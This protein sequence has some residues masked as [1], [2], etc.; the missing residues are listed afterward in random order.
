MHT[1]PYERYIRIACLSLLK[2]IPMEKKPFYDVGVIVG[3]RADQSKVEPL[4]FVLSPTHHL[5]PP[6]PS[7]IVPLPQT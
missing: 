3:R 4:A 5:S 7:P 2:H 6:L 1:F